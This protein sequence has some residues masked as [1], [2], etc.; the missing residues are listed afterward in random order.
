[1]TQER[2]VIYG[3]GEEDG[4]YRTKHTYTVEQAEE[5]RELA[6]MLYRAAWEEAQFNKAKVSATPLVGGEAVNA[7][8]FTGIGRIFRMMAGVGRNTLYPCLLLIS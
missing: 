2:V 5:I 7:R 1:M 3:I 4:Q 6:L 8:G